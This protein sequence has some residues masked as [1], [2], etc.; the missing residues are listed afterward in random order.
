MVEGK[1]ELLQVV[2]RPPHVCHGICVPTHTGSYTQQM[3]VVTPPSRFGCFR[4]LKHVYDN[5]AAALPVTV[6]L[7]RNSGKRG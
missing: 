1:S 2:L 4:H 3:R 5:V 7:F 6:G